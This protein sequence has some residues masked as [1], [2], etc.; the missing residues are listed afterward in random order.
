MDPEQMHH[1]VC[2]FWMCLCVYMKF[3]TV[4]SILCRVTRSVFLKDFSFYLGL[5]HG[6][7]VKYKVEITSVF[8]TGCLKS[9]DMS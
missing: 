4:Y 1:S 6:A 3:I 2:T 5:H 7:H 9:C 8:K